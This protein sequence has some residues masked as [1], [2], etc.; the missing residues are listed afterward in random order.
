VEAAPLIDQLVAEPRTDPESGQ[1]RAGVIGG[2]RLLGRE[3]IREGKHAE[4]EK[5]SR[6]CLKLLEKLPAESARRN[7]PLIHVALGASLLGQKRY[8][9]AQSELLLGYGGMKPPGAHPIAIIRRQQV[10]VLDWLVQLYEEWGKPD[11][12][13]KWRNE[14]QTV[15]PPQKGAMR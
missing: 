7:A 14:R 1:P 4:A 2:L 11:E 3:L 9:E 5:A 8:P 10:E 6:E 12:A 15:R 13:A